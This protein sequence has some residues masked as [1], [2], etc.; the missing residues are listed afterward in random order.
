LEK[1]RKRL[2]IVGSLIFAVG[3]LAGLGLSG[4]FA[5]GG[6]EA[7]LFVASTGDTTLKLACPLMLTASE[8]GIVS[9]DFG[10]PTDEEI[11]PTVRFDVRR[12]DQVREV[13]T[14]LDQMPGQGKK[15][16]WEVSSADNTYGVF[17]M[18]NV[19]ESRQRNF[20]SRQGS[21]GILLLPFSRLPGKTA[22]TLL[23][24]FIMGMIVAGGVL[25]MLNNPNLTGK[26][27]S[28]RSASTA[29]ASAVVAGVLFILLRLWVATGL[30]FLVSLMLSVIMFTEFGLFQD[31]PPVFKK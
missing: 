14:V 7:S 25:W 26:R 12:G 28:L 17:I 24:L 22:I 6:V 10:N 30:L 21:C 19:Y 8:K 18:V 5:W 20:L 31:K 23:Y 4:W 16:Q 27:R 13:S 9:A 11:F 15:L 3:I 1:R 29:L 2:S